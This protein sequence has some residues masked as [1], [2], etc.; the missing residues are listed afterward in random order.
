[1]VCKQNNIGTL[2]CFLEQGKLIKYKNKRAAKNILCNKPPLKMFSISHTFLIE[3]WLCVSFLPSLKLTLTSSCWEGLPDNRGKGARALMGL[4]VIVQKRGGNLEIFWR[5]IFLVQCESM[6][7]HLDLL[8]TIQRNASSLPW[9]RDHILH[10]IPWLEN[11]TPGRNCSF[12]LFKSPPWDQQGLKHLGL[13][14]VRGTSPLTS[15]QRKDCYA[16]LLQRANPLLESFN[17][18]LSSNTLKSSKWS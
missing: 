18:Y 15:L 5:C 7:L 12:D 2:T 16:A 17:Y 10:Q 8:A 1:M 11:H 4:E 14:I 6:I 9:D 13:S 3:F